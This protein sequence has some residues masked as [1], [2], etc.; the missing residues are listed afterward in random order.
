M[1]D[2]SLGTENAGRAPGSACDRAGDLGTAAS[3][4]RAVPSAGFGTCAEDRLLAETVSVHTWAEPRREQPR[5]GGA[6]L[7]TEVPSLH[8]GRRGGGPWA[9]LTSHSP[10]P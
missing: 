10:F 5:E 7:G 3:P 4:L 6:S 1:A 9:L 8:A 2:S